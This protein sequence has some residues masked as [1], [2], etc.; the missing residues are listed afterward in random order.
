MKL[1]EKG[2]IENGEHIIASYKGYFNQS[3]CY[4][5]FYKFISLY[6]K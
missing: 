6:F 4:N 1:I 3:N 2:K 5:L